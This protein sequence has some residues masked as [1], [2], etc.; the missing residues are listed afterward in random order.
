MC[1]VN[2]NTIHHTMKKS[3]NKVF[4]VKSNVE[5]NMRVHEMAR[6]SPQMTRGV[7]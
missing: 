2:T 4:Y 3:R 5:A 6:T 7:V 1:I